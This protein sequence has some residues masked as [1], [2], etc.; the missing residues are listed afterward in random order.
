MSVSKGHWLNHA[1]SRSLQSCL[2]HCAAFSSA[3]RIQR[4]VSGQILR[5]TLRAVRPP[6]RETAGRPLEIVDAQRA[7]LTQRRQ[8]APHH[9]GESIA[10]GQP[11]RH[12]WRCPKCAKP[13]FRGTNPKTRSV[14]SSLTSAELR[15]PY[16]K[17]KTIIQGLACASQAAQAR[18]MIN[19]CGTSTLTEIRR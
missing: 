5:R 19:P 17:Q 6:Y 7:C 18:R 11:S 1:V 10:H 2:S 14:Q 13:G 15:A 8:T 4:G 12:A 16:G 3:A 9:R